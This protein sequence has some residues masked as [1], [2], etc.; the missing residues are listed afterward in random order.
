MNRQKFEEQLKK[1]S[2]DYQ[3]IT[4]DNNQLWL[5]ISSK[6]NVIEQEPL[7]VREIALETPFRTLF[8]KYAPAALIL[9]VI[10][11]SG[12]TAVSAAQKTLP[13]DLLYPLQR[14]IENVHE[15]TIINSKKKTEFKITNAEK[16]LSEIRRMN[17]LHAAKISKAPT[18]AN[19]DDYQEALLDA[20]DHYQESLGNED[21]EPILQEKKDEWEK[22]INALKQATD[23]VETNDQEESDTLD[24]NIADDVKSKNIEIKKIEL[25]SE[26]SSSQDTS[27]DKKD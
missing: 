19:S 10:F 15:K 24:N 23:E 5:S 27:E 13:G 8:M 4:N 25:K 17:A 7:T 1:L 18:V 21:V 26:E 6:I 9:L 3:Q 12:V 20:V 22:R 11:G 2:A 16:R 14:A